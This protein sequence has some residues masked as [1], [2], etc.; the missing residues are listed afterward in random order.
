M[1]LTHANNYSQEA[2]DKS[3]NAAGNAKA[4]N[5]TIKKGLAGAETVVAAEDSSGNSISNVSPL[6]MS[7]RREAAE[8]LQKK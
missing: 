8:R 7:E 4:R 6:S 1:P 3:V 5:D 2:G